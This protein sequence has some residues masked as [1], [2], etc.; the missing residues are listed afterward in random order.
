MK[1]GV[2]NYALMTCGRSIINMKRLFDIVISFIVII[3]L[4]PFLLFLL[5]VNTIATKG[6]PIFIQQRVGRN[7]VLFNIYKFRSLRPQ[8]PSDMSTSSAINMAQYKTP[9]G[10]FLRKTSLDELPQLFNVLKG[11]MSLVG[12]RPLLPN[13]KVLNFYRH[14]YHADRARPGL[15]GLAQIAGRDNLPHNERIYLDEFYVNHNNLWIDLK[16]LWQT[17]GV[18]FFQKNNNG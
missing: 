16:I 13:E 10:S 7:G 11:D 4:S 8:A 17:I 12:P 9:F 3:T 15:T 2:W 5:I 14:Y 6:Q 18:V 1:I